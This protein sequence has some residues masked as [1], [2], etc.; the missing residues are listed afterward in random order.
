MFSM[1]NS[2]QHTRVIHLDR[3]GYPLH[4]VLHWGQ[5]Q[6]PTIRPCDP[7][8]VC[9]LCSTHGLTGLSPI[10][11]VSSLFSHLH[12][13]LP[14]LLHWRGRCPAWSL[15]SEKPYAVLTVEI[16]SLSLSLSPSL[17]WLISMSHLTTVG[18][19]ACLQNHHEGG[20]LFFH[21]CAPKS[22]SYLGCSM[23]SLDRGMEQ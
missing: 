3:S 14:L 18:L 1:D 13:L 7:R 21:T 2:P 5:I 9:P 10:H 6:N 12:L 19:L 23:C 15:S 22:R 16:P 17:P 4:T 8:H 11:L 20:P